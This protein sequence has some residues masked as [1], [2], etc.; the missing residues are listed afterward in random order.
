[1]V[2]RIVLF[3]V[4]LAS[5]VAEDPTSHHVPCKEGKIS[6]GTTM[7]VIFL[8]MVSGGVNL[9]LVTNQVLL[10]L[11]VLVQNIKNTLSLIE[12]SVLSPLQLLR[13]ELGEPSSLIEVWSLARHLKMELLLDIVFIRGRAVVQD[14][15][16]VVGLGDIR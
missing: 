8:S 14:I 16:L 4:D 7:V 2:V 3:D 10:V 6:N 15:V 13:M 12:I 1:M 11:Q 5:S 9:H